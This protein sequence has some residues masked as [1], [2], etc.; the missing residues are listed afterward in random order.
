MIARLVMDDVA[1]ALLGADS[2]SACDVCCVRDETPPVSLQ[3]KSRANAALKRLANPLLYEFVGVEK[4]LARAPESDQASADDTYLSSGPGKPLAS[5]AAMLRWSE[6]IAS[7]PEA[8]QLTALATAISH[9]IASDF[10]ICAAENSDS[11]NVGAIW[12]RLH[13]AASHQN[14]TY[15]DP[16][17]EATVSL[18]A[19][20]DAAD[21]LFLLHERLDDRISL[22]AALRASQ[23]LL[24]H[25]KADGSY[26]GDRVDAATGRVQPDERAGR[27]AAA[28]AAGA[29]IR[30]YQASRI[31]VYVMAALRALRSVMSHLRPECVGD[32]PVSR[33]VRAAAM[34]YAESASLRNQN[35][36]AQAAEWLRLQQ[37]RHSIAPRRNAFSEPSET[38]SALAA[39]DI[40]VAL[41][42]PQWLEQALQSLRQASASRT[43]AGASSIEAYFSTLLAL[44]ALI[45]GCQPDL[46]DGHVRV[47]W[48]SYSADSAANEII[49]VRSV[50]PASAYDVD[51]LPLVSKIGRSVLVPVLAE[52][53]VA[54]VS[55]TS[56]QRTPCLTDLVTGETVYQPASLHDL[57]FDCNYKWGCFLIEN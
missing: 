6:F 29:F 3:L 51:S 18:A 17:G 12:E 33:I 11:R 30:A 44:P 21:Q 28:Y 52:K 24:L 40:F 7:K 13:R 2:S 49:A 26:A 42:Q 39:L 15:S 35:E 47:G 50:D 20:A 41:N 8:V 45:V 19:T 1:P 56:G 10:T 34:L 32:E 55:I 53:H 54:R 43:C 27:K 46:R 31:E 9:G 22:N 25:Q 37:S 57:P 48:T 23:W 4:A 16:F 38:K 14:R 5:A 36:L